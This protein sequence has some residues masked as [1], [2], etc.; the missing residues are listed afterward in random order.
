MRVSRGRFLED[1]GRFLE[2]WG[3]FDFFIFFCFSNF[4]LYDLFLGALRQK[5][6][7]AMVGG[8]RGSFGKVS[9]GFGEFSKKIPD[10]GFFVIF[11]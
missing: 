7:F 9:G 6:R 3:F 4:F 5:V 8:C 1:L 10:L 11:L 2:V